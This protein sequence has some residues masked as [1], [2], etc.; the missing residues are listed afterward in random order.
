[1]EN[2]EYIKRENKKGKKYKVII[3]LLI[4]VIISI[5]V[6]GT[7]LFI[8]KNNKTTS[9]KTVEKKKVYSKYKISG[10]GLED[11]DMH[12]LSL[13]NEEKNKV[14]SPLSIKYALEMLKEGAS[15][16]SRDEIDS[17][18]G[19]Y[20]SKKYT[21]S[22]NMSFANAMFIRNNFKDSIKKSYTDKISNKYNAEIVYDDFTNAENINN[23]VSN[24]TFNL[25]NNLLDDVSHNDFILVNALAIDMEWKKKIQA[26]ITDSYQEKYNVSYSH[27][28]Y[29]EFIV[30]IDGDNYE[31]VNFNDKN[32]KS[33]EIGASINNYDIVNTLGE[34]NIRQTVGEEYKEYMAED[35][36]GSGSSMESVDTYLD[37][38]IKELNSNYKQVKASTDFRFYDDDNLKVFAKE[39]KEYNG[40]ALEYI[41]IMPKVVSLKEYIE[42]MSVKEINNTINNLK[43]VELE[44]FDTGTI[45]K[46]TGYIPLFNYEYELKLKDDL[47]S[48]GIKSV[49]NKDKAD[50]SKLTS[51]KKAFINNATHKANIEFSNEGIKAAAATALGGYG[52]AGCGFDHIYDVPIKT[53]DMTFDKPYLFIIRDKLTGEVWFTG[54]VYE[55]TVN[56]Q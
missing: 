41:G 19:E 40:T 50:L 8:S 38:Y 17:V 16:D 2:D 32:V 26:T 53:I 46:I 42:N 18:V 36:C 54:T 23:W 3:V 55:P 10:N 13:E 44:N 6:G 20:S 48:L 14:Y 45:T 34:A 30:P 31:T 33:V 56:E 47:N 1:M 49:F 21:N 25:V 4:I 39:L 7:F 9:D 22:E 5:I 27:E 51:K 24:K 29:N 37:R 35:P 52:A 15:G 28:K 43:T 12:F 11:F